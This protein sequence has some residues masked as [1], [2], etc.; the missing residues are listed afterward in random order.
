MYIK[1]IENKEQCWKHQKI[2]K[3]NILDQDILVTLFSSIFLIKI[4]LSTETMVGCT[5]FICLKH[6][7]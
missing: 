1:C 6:Q 3:T 5:K 2:L 4:K 7:R